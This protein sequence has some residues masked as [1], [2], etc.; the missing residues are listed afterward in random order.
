M[1]PVREGF[2]A[3]GQWGRW[4]GWLC[5]TSWPIHLPRR[6]FSIQNSQLVYQKKLKVRSG[7]LLHGPSHLGLG[8]ADQWD[9]HRAKDIV[10]HH[11]LSGQGQ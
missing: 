8:W 9:L 4:G 11:S 7:P 2:P 5:L 3:E 10:G 1:E 6:W